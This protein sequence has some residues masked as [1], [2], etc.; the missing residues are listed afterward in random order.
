MYGLDPEMKKHRG[1]KRTSLIG[2]L[3][4]ELHNVLLNDLSHVHA[5]MF[6]V[7]N[8]HHRTV[9]SATDIVGI[10]GRHSFAELSPNDIMRRINEHE[11]RTM[12]E[13]FPVVEP[14][15]LVSGT[16]PSRIQEVWDYSGT[17]HH[18]SRRW[19]Y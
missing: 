18:S 19:I 4:T 11:V 8:F 14:G 7:Y 12:A 16:A 2:V 6:P 15:S 1:K 17:E 10:I 9:A 3:C 5:C 13:H